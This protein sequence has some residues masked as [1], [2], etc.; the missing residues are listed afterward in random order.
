MITYLC[1]K[2]EV[3][4]SLVLKSTSHLDVNTPPAARATTLGS[5][6]PEP[7]QNHHTSR[8]KSMFVSSD[9]FPLNDKPFEQHPQ[10]VIAPPRKKRRAPEPPVP[11]NSHIPAQQENQSL[12]ENIEI[13][14]DTNERFPTLQEQAESHEEIPHTSVLSQPVSCDEVIHDTNGHCHLNLNGRQ[15]SESHDANQIQI[16]TDINV[17]SSINTED[18]NEN[19]KANLTS[20]EV[21][22]KD[23]LNESA[24]LKTD[25]SNSSPIDD[26]DTSS[27]HEKIKAPVPP[28][29]VLTSS[30][31]T[32]ETSSPS[33]P[34]PSIEATASI[35]TLQ[36][37]AVEKDCVHLVQTHS[38]L[39]LLFF[40]F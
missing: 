17:N 36:S 38:G 30:S 32:M 34:S 26:S 24:E 8:P 13:N 6:S 18:I 16:N 28:S 23:T 7:D 22:L 2:Q 20:K 4:R 1:L 21:V 3:R 39:C 5:V 29:P 35:D 10:P 31:H 40:F 19:S 37:S 33:L 14:T 11:P 9:T 25:T 27:T 15:S 12:R